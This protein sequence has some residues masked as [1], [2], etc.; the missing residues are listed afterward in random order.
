MG[1]PN[2][3]AAGKLGI[4]GPAGPPSLARRRLLA[5][6]SRRTDLLVRR[7]SATD[8]EVGPTVRR[9]WTGKSVLLLRAAP[10]PKPALSQPLNCGFPLKD[11]RRRLSDQWASIYGWRSVRRKRRRPSTV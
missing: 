3:S 7:L 1:R 11:A 9:R 8:L 2:D 10:S 5:K 6:H 4:P